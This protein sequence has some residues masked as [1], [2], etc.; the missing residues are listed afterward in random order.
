[1]SKIQKIKNSKQLLEVIIMKT[2]KI[3]E[4]A[5]CC[6]TGLCGVSINP[7]LLRISTVLDGLKKKGVNVERYN[8]S[9]APQMFIANQ[10][11]CEM[12][13]KDGIN[14]LPI[15][16][17]DN[18]AVITKRYPTNDEFIK[19]LEI[20]GDYIA[21]NANKSKCCCRCKKGDCK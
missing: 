21:G 15:I 8:L 11:I 4:P 12:L 19:L 18:V 14:I 10:I 7:E 17:V 3:Y 9:S 5:M 2:M 16:M 13:D 6:S 1:M 20:P